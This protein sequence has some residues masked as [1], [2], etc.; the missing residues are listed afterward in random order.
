MNSKRGVSPR[1]TIAQALAIAIEHQRA[2]RREL[3]ERIYHQILAADP[4]Q[5]D[6]IHLLGVLA[7]E[8]GRHEIASD[9]IR[10]AIELVPTSG[11][12]H[13]NLG[14]VCSARENWTRRSRAIRNRSSSIPPARYAQTTW[15]MHLRHRTAWTTLSPANH[16]AIALEPNHPYAHQNLGNVL[17]AQ[18]YFVE[19]KAS[20]R[21]A[22][23]LKPD[24]FEAHNSLGALA[25]R[26]GASRRSDRMLAAFAR[27]Q[28]RLRRGA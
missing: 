14:N 8:V 21:Q 10:R 1:F 2:G 23:E 25:A 9:Y 12:F 5:A 22:I 4:R 18:G 15:A 16:R 26:R 6:A 27:V 20:Y 7:L 24:Y 28:A 19:A 17:M 13:F 11:I 3:A